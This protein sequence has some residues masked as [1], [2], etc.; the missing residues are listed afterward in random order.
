PTPLPAV[1]LG[2]PGHR[3][4]STARIARRL[5]AEAS[6]ALSAF[7]RRHRLTVNTVLQGAWALLLARHAG[8]DDVV[9]GATVSG[10]PDQLAGAESMVGMLINTLPVRVRVEST[11]P[12]ADWLA[13]LQ[14]S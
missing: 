13:Q 10:R 14:R 2:A 9:F 8:V 6:G 4:G 12:V 3:T 7:A 11:A 1:R 5:S